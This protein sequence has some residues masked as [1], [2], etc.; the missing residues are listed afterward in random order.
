MEELL[1]KYKEY[2]LA[3]KQSLNYYN[4]IKIFLNYLQDNNIEI[5]NI[6][7]ETITK[8]FNSHS[9]Y[10]NNTRNQFIK[11]GRNFFDFMRIEVNEWKKIK[12]MKIQKRKPKFLSEEE[13]KD[14][15]KYYCTYENRL[16]R[17]DKADTFIN[18]VYYTGLRKEEILKLKRADIDLKANPCVI[19]II[20]KG[21]KERRVYFSDKYSPQLKKKL[22]NYFAAEPEQNNAFNLTIGKINYFFR[23]MNKY[24]KDRGITPHL[25]RHSF[26]KYMESKGVPLTQ[27]SKLYGHSSLAT[28]MIYLDPTEDMIKNTFKEE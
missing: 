1:Q 26:G 8:F 2:L 6:T 4:I 7:Q 9:E 22:K 23:K 11:A 18:F 5:Q 19:T 12:Y 20:G 27:I 17:P 10:S 24:L 21:N 13:L 15:I 25:F 16:M 14:I 28:T 3:R